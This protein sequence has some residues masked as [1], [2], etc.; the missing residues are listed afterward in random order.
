MH[1]AAME[2]HSHVVPILLSDGRIDPN[3]RDGVYKDIKYPSNALLT[4]AISSHQDGKTA[5]ERADVAKY[6]E[7][8]TMLFDDRRVVDTLHPL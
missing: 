5:L 7:I 1:C 6:S 8:V 2:G 4:L 3:N